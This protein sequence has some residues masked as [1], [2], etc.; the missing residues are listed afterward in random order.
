MKRKYK[1]LIGI[2][3]T[4]IVIRLILPSVVLHYANKELAEMDGYYGHIE[5]IDISLFRG[6]YQINDIYL[7]KTDS[8]TGK[9]T[10]FFKA[11]N[12]DLSL[13]WSSIFKGAIVGEL[14]FDSPELIFTAEV[15]EL[16]DIK[17]DTTDF[18]ALLKDFMPLKVNRFEVNN[19]TLRYIDSIA[20]PPLNILLTDIHVLAFNLT[21]VTDDGVELPAT[22]TA[23]AAVYEGVL[24]VN[25][26]MDA[27]AEEPTFDLNAELKGTNLVLLNDFF[28]AYGNFDVNSGVFGLFTELAA[29]EGKFAGY[30]KPILENLDV[31]GPEDR[32]DS[33]LSRFWEA[34]VGATGVVF[35]NQKEDQFATKVAIEGDFEDPKIKVVEAIWEVLRN[36]FI[37]A[38]V[39]KVDN[40]ITIESVGNE[41]GKRSFKEIFSR[42]RKDKKTSK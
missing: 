36:A 22:I 9:Q 32:S 29:K 17:G 11:D 25:M 8:V 1:I 15:V 37:Q 24:D 26:K 7:N 42:E 40:E 30:V 5:D 34:A 27:L 13:E 16:N 28:Q 4:L 41:N 38:L 31:V 35:K 6:A 39:P 23:E 12:I 10:P 21:N 33:F 14:V 3:V 19:G 18:K 2:G 20:K